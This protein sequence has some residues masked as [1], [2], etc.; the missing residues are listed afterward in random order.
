MSQESSSIDLENVS[1]SFGQT[2][3][4]ASTTPLFDTIPNDACE[5]F[6]DH[7]GSLLIEDE[8][9]FIEIEKIM[10]ETIYGVE[11]E[12]ITATSECKALLILFI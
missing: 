8:D 4:Q 3:A 7:F 2:E 6:C 11:E 12:E 9:L 10:S 1:I 5:V